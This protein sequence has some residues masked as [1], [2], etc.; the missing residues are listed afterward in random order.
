MLKIIIF[1]LVLFLKKGKFALHQKKHSQV[2]MENVS[3][4]GPFK[5]SSDPFGPLLNLPS[6]FM[7]LPRGLQGAHRQQQM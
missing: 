6:P 3:L 4:D 5:H 1:Y 2:E 7:S